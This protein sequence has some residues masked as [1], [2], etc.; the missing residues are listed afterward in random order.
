[1]SGLRSPGHSTTPRHLS[2]QANAAAKKC[3]EFNLD[4]E[5]T[6]ENKL[7]WY[8]QLRKQYA[9]FKIHCTIL[10]SATLL[11]TFR[12]L[13]TTLSGTFLSPQ[14]FPPWSRLTRNLPSRHLW[15]PLQVLC[16]L[17]Q[18][19]N[20]P[21]SPTKLFRNPLKSEPARNHLK[22]CYQTSPNLPK[23]HPKSSDWLKLHRILLLGKK[24]I[25]T[26]RHTSKTL[27]EIW[28][29][30]K[31]RKKKTSWKPS[32]VANTLSPDSLDL[33]FNQHQKK[34]LKPLGSL[35]RIR[36]VLKTSSHLGNKPKRRS[37]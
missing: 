22:P 20:L 30:L 26:V 18:T 17:P 25:H 9:A 21:L 4:W 3:K 33:H 34:S 10:W 12:H 1:M 35:Q 29:N 8:P 27:T 36:G 5:G 14:G 2:K 7:R 32:P 31:Q 24:E 19:W 13:P 28:K 16:N 6:K 11:K 37:W 23:S 15:E